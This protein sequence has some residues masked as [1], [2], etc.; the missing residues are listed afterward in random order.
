MPICRPL[1][2][3]K[4]TSTKTARDRLTWITSLSLDAPLVVIAWQHAVSAHYSTGLSVHH[5]VIV[6]MAVW[7]GYTADR[8]LDAWR[9]E[10]NVSRRHSL[11]AKYRWA[12]LVAWTLVCGGSILLSLAKLSSLELRNGIALAS[13]S[14]LATVVIQTHPFGKRRA[15]T[16][17][18]LTTF[19]VTGSVLLFAAPESRA[20][21]ATTVTIMAPLFLLNCL[22][23]HSWDRSIDAR[24]NPGEATRPSRFTIPI[25]TTICLGTNLYLLSANPLA[26]YAIVSAALLVSLHLLPQSLH[27]ETRRTLADLSLLTPLI[28]LI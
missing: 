26:G 16:K 19:L 20:H 1:P 2:T 17:S 25:A 24:Q 27:V 8:W 7:L 14:L 22:L 12:F 10:E 15:L 5:R 11:H 21:T 28:M 13:T 3:L 6:F 9:H 18:L 23:I 4:T